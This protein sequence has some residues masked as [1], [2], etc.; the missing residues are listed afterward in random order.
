MPGHVVIIIIIVCIIYDDDVGGG[1]DSD[2]ENGNAGDSGG[3][4][5]CK[6]HNRIACQR[7][8]ESSSVEN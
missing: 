5:Y 7:I 2:D 1:S 4:L 3:N 8:K 6:L